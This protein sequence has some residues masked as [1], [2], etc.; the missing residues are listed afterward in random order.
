MMKSQVGAKHYRYAV[1]NYDEQFEDGYCFKSMLDE[2]EVER[3][4][5]VAAEHLDDAVKLD[6]ELMRWSPH[7]LNCL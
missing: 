2:D 7:C 5:Q 1:L 6:W 3:L 4:A